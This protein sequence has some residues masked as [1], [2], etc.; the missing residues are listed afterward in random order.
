MKKSLLF[1]SLASLIAISLNACGQAETPVTPLDADKILDNQ[2]YEDAVSTLNADRCSN[3]KDEAVKSECSKAVTGLNLTNEA[4]E[5]LDKSICSKIE[6]ER[7][8]ENCNTEVE[9]KIAESKISEEKK[10]FYEE[11]N[12]LAEKYY[13]EDN[14]EGC[15]EIE[16]ETFRKQCEDNILTQRGLNK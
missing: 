3:I 10:S 1:L 9:N 12:A 7:Y 2:I 16:D 13:N 14:L 4:M 5:K 11:Q 6:L 15:A 8:K